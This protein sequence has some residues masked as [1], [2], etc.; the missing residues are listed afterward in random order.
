M[1]Y[2][3]IAKCP[4]TNKFGVG[5]TTF[6]MACGRRYESVR[7]NVGVSKSQSFYL[8]YVDPLALNMLGQGFVPQHIMEMLRA[9]DTDFEYRQFGIIDRENRIAMHTGS[10]C[11]VWAGHR[12][13]PYYAAYG[14]GL[15]GP[16]T[17]DGII[18]GFLRDPEAPLEERLLIALEGGRDAGGQMSNGVPRPERSAWIRVVGELEFPE[19]DVRVDLHNNTVAELRRVLTEF[20]KYRAFYAR[21]EANPGSLEL[22]EEEFVTSLA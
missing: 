2:S 20:K 3:I 21:R 12:V 22:T 6:S 9:E 18:A 14:N 4:R 19:I 13:G 1:T 8:R 15:A 10:A 5:S 11:G 16:Q 17:V 7:P